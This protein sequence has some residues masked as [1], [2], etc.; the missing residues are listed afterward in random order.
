M[1][2]QCGQAGLS[3]A[4]FDSGTAERQADRAVKSPKTAHEPS[5]GCGNQK[6]FQKPIQC[7]VYAAVRDVQEGT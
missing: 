4:R 6:P 1:Q 3:L 2:A 5:N 7:T